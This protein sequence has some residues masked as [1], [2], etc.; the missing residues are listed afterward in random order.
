MKI[1][2]DS[3]RALN[4][5]KEMFASYWNRKKIEETQV[6]EIKSSAVTVPLST[7]NKKIFNI[8][9][10]TAWWVANLSAIV[11]FEK[12]GSCLD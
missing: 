11:I 5:N 9:E 6:L 2:N 7:T 3:S 8:H 1:S 12:Y 10:E 4:W